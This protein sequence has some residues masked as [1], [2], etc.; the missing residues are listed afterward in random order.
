MVSH[1]GI[2]I[3]VVTVAIMLKIML[4]QHDFDPHYDFY[5]ILFRNEIFSVKVF[6]EVLKISNL[7][8]SL[9]MFETS[10]ERILASKF[11]YLL[12]T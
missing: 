2:F 12:N 10:H 8:L 1:R 3:L 6:C 11:V 7:G 9:Y 4:L 5:C